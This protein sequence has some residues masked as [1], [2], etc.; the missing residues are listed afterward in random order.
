MEENLKHLIGK[1]TRLSLKYYLYLLIQGK[2]SQNFSSSRPKCIDV[3]RCEMP[4]EFISNNTNENITE[5][6]TS[7]WTDAENPPEY[8]DMLHFKCKHD[9]YKMTIEGTDLFCK[10][11]SFC[12]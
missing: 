10:Y 12:N 2:Y 4:S 9:N 11:I 6:W 7:S 8:E 5:L 3:P 1:Q